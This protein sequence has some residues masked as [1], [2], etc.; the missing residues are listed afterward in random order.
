M[1]TPPFLRDKT[2][3][4]TPKGRVYTRPWE[5]LSASWDSWDHCTSFVPRYRFVWMEKLKAK[6]IKL[7]VK[8][9]LVHLVK[10]NRATTILC[11]AQVNVSGGLHF[12]PLLHSRTFRC[13][14]TP[15]STH[16]D[17]L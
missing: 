15:D 14:I 5:G 11:C 2:N 17:L 6:I 3:P 1:N 4:S 12:I 10:D 7:D 13:S 9:V 16:T 8:D